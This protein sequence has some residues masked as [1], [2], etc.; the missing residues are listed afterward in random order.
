MTRVHERNGTVDACEPTPTPVAFEILYA[1]LQ[2]LARRQLGASP[3]TLLCTTALVHEAYLK[4]EAAA[5]PFERGPFLA[6][7][8]KTMRH[9]V[10]DHVRSRVAA[11]RGGGAHAVTLDTD[12]VL[13]VGGDP[14]DLLTVEQGLQSLEALDPR[15]VSVVECHFFAGMNFDEIAQ[16]L[17]L[18]E[19]TVRRDWRRARA[20]LQARLADARA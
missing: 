18:S 3:R 15:L 16:A 19:R 2:R 14:V 9:V 5:A 12:V 11:K 6:L 13:A 17:E 1:E 8:A 20:F 4:L 7:A 10:I